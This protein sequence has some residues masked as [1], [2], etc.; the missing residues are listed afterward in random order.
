MTASSDTR[1]DSGAAT[2]GDVFAVVYTAVYFA[3][4]ALRTPGT[5]ASEL[6]GGLAFLP[7]GPMTAWQ[8]WR[9]AS[10]PGLDRR[11]R[12]AWLL[13]SVSALILFLSG[14]VW[15]TYLHF[16]GPA[17]T[18]AWIDVLEP[19]RCGI[20]VAACLSFPRRRLEGAS[21]T[22]QQ[23]DVGI[24][25]V[26]GVAI[27]FYF[28]LEL[29][30]AVVPFGR[31]FA[32]M[33]G[34][35]IGSLV[36]L[37]AAAGVVRKRDR[38]SRVALLFTALASVAYVAADY[39]YALLVYGAGP[40]S[41]RGGHAVDGL[42][43][44]AWMFRWL[45]ARVSRTSYES[46]LAGPAADA[47]T[48]LPD[49]ESPRFSY[50]VV[51]GAFLVLIGR[52]YA[53]DARLLGLL[54]VS[55]AVMVV[56][57]VARQFVAIRENDELFRRQLDNE[58]RFRSVVQL[59][60][61]ITLVVD[62]GGTIT[63]ASPAAAATFGPDTAVRPGSRLIDVVREDGRRAVA[64]VIGTGRGPR[65]LL[66]HLPAA[67]ADWREIEALWTDLRGDPAVGGFVINCRDITA[68]AELKRDLRHA[69]RLGAVGRL[70]DGLAHEVNNSLTII[71]G[72]VD[73]VGAELE[74]GDPAVG[75]LAS[76]RQAVDRAGNLTRRVLAFSRRQPAR[77]SVVD[78]NSLVQDLFSVLS[79]S[80]TSKV[81]VRFTLA[82]DL[83]AV[84][85][86]PGQIE[87]V[88]TNLA[89][90]ARDAMPDGGIFEIATLNRV[91]EAPADEGGPPPGSYVAVVVTDTG[92][93]MAPEV[94]R[95]IF[96]P[97]FSTKAPGAGM[98][99][100]LAMVNEI[101]RDSGGCVSVESAPGQG[102][103]FTILLPRTIE[104]A[105]AGG[106]T[107]EPAGQPGR[108]RERTVLVA[109]DEPFVRSVTRRILER[110]GYKVIEAEGGPQALSIIDDSA[111]LFDLL[112]TD[113]VMPGVHGRQLIARCLER[114]PD[115]PAVCM[116]GFA[117][118]QADLG[119]Y[120]SNL[121]QV[122]F[123]PF[124]ADALVRAVAGAIESRRVP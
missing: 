22:R 35:A 102:T 58:A 1:A 117:G 71:G 3:W 21:R 75:D 46:D 63:Y 74:A 54:A 53:H 41:Y 72:V 86:D 51:A 95:R 48:P 111:V 55:T 62:P 81:A 104:P 90:N 50:L 66:F 37:V 49:Y 98:G 20:V 39:V 88:L 17:I 116:T 87:Q 23:L 44:E 14:T 61:D 94:A 99:L 91:V 112:L 57:L 45:A 93:G 122:L 26:A 76:I 10:V 82:A 30:L 105:P 67:A 9:T 68:R 60:S 25:L 47:A 2:A 31:V 83:W 65:R 114:R 115:V 8:C 40:P 7:L 18:P 19:I 15:T 110:H 36:F 107:A 84:R 100:G 59:S 80:L 29:W 73:L 69:Q 4:L 27:A 12:A 101:V 64:G 77:R 97:F 118:E 109:D 13:F 79:R 43:F 56:M 42:W 119:V 96:E 121:A 124:T 85:V 120:G 28:G 34:P 52:I 92:V 24:V 103:S 11:S 5:P 70:A 89:T 108:E 32:A 123:K 33:G 78:L 6:I 38:G 106:E 16:S 113:L